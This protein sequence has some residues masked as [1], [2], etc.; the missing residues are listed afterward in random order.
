MTRLDIRLLGEFAVLTDGVPLTTI[1]SQ[2]LQ[3]MLAYLLLHR[4][5]PVARQRLAFLF[6]PDSTEAQARSNLR[7]LLHAL[8]Q[9]LPTNGDHFVET[10]GQTV[11]WL[12]GTP[13]TLDVDSL[14]TS[15]AKAQTAQDLQ[16]ALDLYRGPLLPSCYDDWIVPERE[17]LEQRVADVLQRFI[18]RLEQE[19]SYR[20]AITFAQQL[21]RRDPLREDLYRQ[22]MRLYA[23]SGDRAGIARTYKEC[24]SV[25]QHEL[26][27]DP[28]RQTVQAYERCLRMETPGV[29]APLTALDPR[30]VP[31]QPDPPR[32]T[33]PV[34]AAMPAASNGAK[35]AALTPIIP[36]DV[37]AP[38]KIRRAILSDALQAPSTAIPLAI[39]TMALIYWLLFVPRTG[40]GGPFALVLLALAGS[41]AVASFIWLFVI[42]YDRTYEER[43]RAALAQQQRV[44]REQ[45]QAGVEVVR[46]K[47][48]DGFAAIAC[49]EGQYALKALDYEFNELKGLLARHKERD[50]LAV[51]HLPALVNA[52]YLQGLSVL[53]DALELARSVASPT[54]QRLESNLKDLN[55]K[56]DAAKAKAGADEQIKLWRA[57]ASSDRQ[58]LDLV[59]QQRLHLQQLLQ[60]SDRC[61]GALQQTRMELASL[62]A[63]ASSVSVDSVLETLQKTIDQAKAIQEE[64]RKLGY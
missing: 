14:L 20:D 35:G 58:R 1:N 10:D 37:L 49:T 53:D 29:R 27:V 40:W 22:I 32:A 47:L 39:A 64:M 43:S 6:W 45:Q 23:L 17:R 16:Q 63:D 31:A 61:E 21:V 28:S 34:P 46:G 62:K 15:L 60:Q 54:N 38:D 41:A 44:E 4:D 7:N 12:P 5:T 26:D 19:G 42:R 18:D 24:R 2:R 13:Y 25:L 57:K 36:E 50:P 33:L 30:T 9:A 51:A 8:S 11:Q 48:R 52:T 59:D 56:I 55:A 3:C